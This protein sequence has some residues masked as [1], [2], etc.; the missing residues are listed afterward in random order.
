MPAGLPTT[1][2]LEPNPPT[3]GALPDPGDNLDALSVPLEDYPIFFSLDAAFPDPLEGPPLAP[4]SGTAAAN[5]LSGGDVLVSFMTAVGPQ[6]GLYAPANMLGLDLV[7]QEPDTDDL[8]ALLLFDRLEFEDQEERFYEPGSDFLAFSVRR[9]SAVVG[10]ADS[11]W[12]IPI[13]E[14]D[15]LVPPGTPLPA[16]HP[17]GL[18]AVPGPL[19]GIAIFAESLDLWTL[20]SNG[21]SEFGPFGD[22]LDA[23]VPEPSAVALLA[24]AAALAGLALLRRRRE[25][26]GA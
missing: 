14:G 16:N 7:G 18:A 10:A 21:P 22:D 1:D 3:P 25:T 26:L 19:P 12:G 20:R 4:N 6:I 9:G 2:L 13:E 11:L 5:L 17:T 8:D 23:V 24:V 15:I